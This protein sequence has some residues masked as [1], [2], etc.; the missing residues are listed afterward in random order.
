MVI[1][2]SGVQYRDGSKYAY[3]ISVLL[4]QSCRVSKLDPFSLGVLFSYNTLFFFSLSLNKNI[5]Y[6]NK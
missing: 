2:L 3:G 6:K 5:F 4:A 1:G